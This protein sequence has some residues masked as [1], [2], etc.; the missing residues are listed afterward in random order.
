ARME[1]AEL[2]VHRNNTLHDLLLSL[3]PSPPRTAGLKPDCR[4]KNSLDLA[5]VGPALAGLH[6]CQAEA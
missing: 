5:V 2:P 3:T 1:R 6:A 4:W